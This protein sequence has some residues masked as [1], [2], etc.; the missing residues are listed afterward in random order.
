MEVLG[1]EQ[2]VLHSYWPKMQL[3]GWDN[4][5]EVRNARTI[6]LDLS[7]HAVYHL[8]CCLTIAANWCQYA[9]PYNCKV[10]RHMPLVKIIKSKQPSFCGRT[11]FFITY[12]ASTS[13]RLGFSKER[14]NFIHRDWRDLFPAFQLDHKL[15]NFQL[16]C[17]L[18]EKK[19]WLLKTELKKLRYSNYY[20]VKTAELQL[21][22]WHFAP[23]LSSALTNSHLCFNGPCEFRLSQ[24]FKIST[25]APCV[26]V[27][28]VIVWIRRE[29]RHQV[30]IPAIRRVSSRNHWCW[31]CAH[32]LKILD[33]SLS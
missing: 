2:P 1:R 33:L 7:D 18:Q 24:T 20:P 21:V 32:V 5:N 14:S 3:T 28:H 17:F 31:S 11:K 29:L 4:C 22:C 23:D 16:V 19:T 15:M 8:Y 10:K 12:L 30:T 27:S 13:R 25:N 9:E 6:K 26:F